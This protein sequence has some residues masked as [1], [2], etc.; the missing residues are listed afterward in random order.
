MTIEEKAK[1]TILVSLLEEETLDVTV[2]SEKAGLS[3]VEFKK[4]FKELVTSGYI[5]E[6]TTDGF[7][8]ASI[9]SAGV[10]HLVKLKSVDVK[11]AI[12]TSKFLKVVKNVAGKKKD[13]LGGKLNKA[14]DSLTDFL[15]AKGKDLEKAK[16]EK[17]TKDSQPQDETVE[18][19]DE[20]IEEIKI[21]F[22]MEDEPELPEGV[23]EL[24]KDALKNS[25][26]KGQ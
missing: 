25:D 21:F 8:G 1:L 11:E 2:L 3:N 12:K 5:V 23:A 22:A 14:S 9:T 19:T 7:M 17:A 20:E 10:N 13:S 4:V 6:K 24:I 15:I 26:F 18:A 16:A